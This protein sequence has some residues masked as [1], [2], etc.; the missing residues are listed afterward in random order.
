MKLKSPKNKGSRFEYFIRD[1]LRGYGFEARRTPMSG[2][3]DGWSGDITSNFP[4]FIECK[5][6]AKTIFP[7][8]YKKAND[9]SGSKPPV[10]VWNYKGQAYGFML[11][12]DIINLIVNKP[13]VKISF[14]KSPKPQKEDKSIG[15]KFSKSSQL[16]KT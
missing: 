6:T 4:L 14:K 7:Q 11:F 13:M 15:L 12:S 8:W 2:A 1:L 5:N 3:I 16:H 9:E 10:I